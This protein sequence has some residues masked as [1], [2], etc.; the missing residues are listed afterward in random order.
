MSNHKT[1]LILVLL[2][3]C[4]ATPTVM[5]KNYKNE[6]VKEFYW[7]KFKTKIEVNFNGSIDTL[8]D[9]QNKNFHEFKSKIPLIEDSIFIKIFEYYSDAYKDYISGIKSDGDDPESEL[10]QKIIPKPS[11]SQALL[12]HYTPLAIYLPSGKDCKPGYF[13]I[14]FD[15]TWDINNSLGIVIKDWKVFMVGNGDRAFLF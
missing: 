4:K 5:K 7:E 15:C 10:V 3:S 14:Y 8:T 1:I 11:N 6:I 12:K 9:C 2:L 13:G